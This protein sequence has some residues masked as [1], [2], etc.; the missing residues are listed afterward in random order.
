M[1]MPAKAD[2][3]KAKSLIKMAE[4]TL[5]RLESTDMLKYPGNTLTDYYDVIH[6]LMEALILSTGVKIRGEG[7]HMEL[8]DYV[9]GEC[10]FDEKTRLFLQKMREHRNRISYE[11]FMIHENYISL[12]GKAIKEIVKKL[13]DELGK[14]G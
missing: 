14:K 3:Q 1:I 7:A 12:N 5:E 13:F 8:I 9:S 10:G 11:G 4:T 2:R 6:K